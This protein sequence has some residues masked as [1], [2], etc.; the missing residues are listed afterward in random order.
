[1]TVATTKIAEAVSAAKA[2]VSSEAKARV[3][4]E[5]RQC[6]QCKKTKAKSDVTKEQVKKHRAVCRER[7]AQRVDWSED[8][9]GASCP[10]STL[11]STAG[12]HAP[13][14]S[15]QPRR[16]LRNLSKGA[17][18][19]GCSGRARVR[20]GYEP[21]RVDR[22]ES[23]SGAS[24]PLFQSSNPRPPSPPFLAVHPIQYMTNLL[25][26]CQVGWCKPLGLPGST[27][28]VTREFHITTTTT[29]AVWCVPH[30]IHPHLLHSLPL[31]QSIDP[32][33]EPE[34]MMTRAPRQV[35]DSATTDGGGDHW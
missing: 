16:A 11:S 21:R 13:Y 23:T 30:R 32:G 19:V 4:E 25:C 10:V 3:R 9:A 6:D 26:Y 35:I 24:P 17:C 12:P 18:G 5:E 31:L 28:G 2:H 8:I 27:P 34:S 29:R 33:F 1:M 7:E 15:R 20:R 22:P 14:L